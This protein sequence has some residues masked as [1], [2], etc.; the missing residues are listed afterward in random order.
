MI[1]RADQSIRTDIA[2]SVWLETAQAAPRASQFEGSADCDVTIIGGGFS[3]LATAL[4]LAKRGKSVVLLESGEIGQGASGLNLGHCTPTFSKASFDDLRGRYGALAERMITLQAGSADLVCEV[5]GDHNIDCGWVR[6]GMVRASRT[7]AG[8]ARLKQ[9]V[10]D[11]RGMGHE[12]RFLSASDVEAMTGAHGYAGGW[13]NAAA[14][15]LNP[16]AYCRGLARAAIQA[17]AQ[18]H[19]RSHV[20]SITRRVDGWT[21]ETASGSVQSEHVVLATGVYTGNIHPEL[22]RTFVSTAIAAFATE[23]VDAA[24]RQKVLPEDT[25]FTDASQPSIILSYDPEGRLVSALPAGRVHR[26]TAKQ[27]LKLAR[28]RV[29]RSFPALKDTEWKYFWRAYVD[30]NPGS[31]AEIFDFGAGGHAL[32]GFSGR[33]VPTCTAYAKVLVDRILGTPDAELALPVRAASPVPFGFRLK[34]NGLL[35]LASLHNSA[36]YAA[37]SLHILK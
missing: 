17:G 35:E 29:S 28:L 20:S 7:A 23:P 9:D 5:I 31:Q 37:A 15:H 12:T 2:R 1:S 25:T 21:T 14:G 33:G 22:S 30:Y 26:Q 36:E 10:T 24:L 16:L 3:G 4:F 32:V 8:L 18:V 11:Y 6:T 13:F 34:T 19:I 27:M